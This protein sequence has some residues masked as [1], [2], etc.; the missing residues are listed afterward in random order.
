MQ[1]TGGF[2]TEDIDLRAAVNA[3]SDVIANRPRPLRDFDQIYMKAADMV[4][5]AQLVAKWAD[6]RRLTFVGDGDAIGVSVAHFRGL[7]IIEYGPTEIRVLDFDERMVTSVER[8]A[9]HEGLP[10]LSAGLYNVLD[11][12][13]AGA[14]CDCFY[15]NPPWGAS[16]AG[17]SVKVFTQRGFELIGYAGDGMVVIAD[18]HDEY[19]WTSEVLANVQRFAAEQGFYV[20]R[21]MPQLH[22]YHLDD[23]PELRSCNLMLRSVPG[24]GRTPSSELILDPARLANFYGSDSPPTVRY[25]RERFRVDYGKAHEDEYSLELLE[26]V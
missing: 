20:A 22:S 23:A 6:G 8:F 14:A 7:G 11:P 24:N 5:Q 4:L 16:N 19:P 1:D 13:P 3:I 2:L 21:L 17:E 18:R 12:I 26:G 9:D 15:T 10:W 25:I